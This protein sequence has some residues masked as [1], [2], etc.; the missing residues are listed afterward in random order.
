[1]SQID[2]LQDFLDMLN[3]VK[4]RRGGKYKALCPAHEDHEPS[5]SVYESCGKILVY[6]WGGC[7]TSKV[8]G[9]MGL[10]MADLFLN[11]DMQD[12]SSNI[13]K[14]YDYVNTN[15]EL[16]FQVVRTEDKKFF[17]R[18]LDDDGRPIWGLKSGLYKLVNGDW[19][20]LKH[21][22][23]P[24][25]HK[26]KNFEGIDHKPLYNLPPVLKAIEDD[27]WVV[28]V[29]GEKD[30]ENLGREGIIGTT[31]PQGANKW[32]ER[33]SETLKGA[34]VAVIPDNDEP[35]IN[36]AHSVANSLLDVAKTVRLIDFP[37]LFDKVKEKGGRD[38]TDWLKQGGTKEKLLKMIREAPEWERIDPPYEEQKSPNP[39]QRDSIPQD[40]PDTK[41]QEDL[42]AHEKLLQI[43][44]Q[45]NLFRSSGNRLFAE[46]EEDGRPYIFEIQEKGGGFQDWL[47]RR[48]K[49]VYSKVPHS[50]ALSRTMKGIRADCRKAT[51]RKIYKR[52]ADLGNK[53]LLDL[54]GDERKAVKI[55]PEKYKVVNEPEIVFWRP[56]GAQKLPTPNGTVEDLKHLD[57]L[58]NIEGEDLALLIAWL[59]MAFQT[60]GSYPILIP[61]GAA[62]SGKSTLTK[63]IRKLLDPA[64]QSG[65]TVMGSVEN[66]KDLYSVAKHRHIIAL[67][68]M[69]K[70]QK[71][72]SDA[73]AGIATQS[74]KESRQLYTDDDLSTIDTMNPIVMNGIDIS[75]TGD[76]LMDRAILLHLSKPDQRKTEEEL[77]KK[78]D[79]FWD[80]ILGGLCD[81]LTTALANRGNVEV[82]QEEITRMADFTKWIKAATSAIKRVDGLQDVEPIEAYHANRKSAAEDALQETDLG[83]ALQGFLEMQREENGVLWDGPATELLDQL[84]SYAED[85]VKESKYWPVSPVSLGKRLK[86]TKPTLEKVGINHKK[87]KTREG[88]K[89]IFTTD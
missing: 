28:V 5:L 63:M 87:D 34:K 49:K 50:T 19:R 12:E 27:R 47:I 40:S 22:D 59:L 80:K 61:T 53:I 64:G 71:W 44:T 79:I 20:Q 3:K 73:L 85:S 86:K 25:K 31:N 84:E 36:H 24:N 65:K 72:Q 15:K 21:N 30:V 74:G 89:H 60:K 52:V 4:D 54:G 83:S 9:T 62:G 10:E 45:G 55:T 17:Q 88:R 67:D 8:V 16:V 33:Y 37:N 41:D 58:L 35:G 78:F 14:T 43:T 26:T 2:S 81:A 69:S 57:S 29:E 76:D 13:T 51:Q 75:G 77:W 68:N 38:V 39:S 6:C 11:S 23:D 42:T 18:R 56:D 32:K 7:P 70:L 46:V 82:T 48:Y 66:K 1:M